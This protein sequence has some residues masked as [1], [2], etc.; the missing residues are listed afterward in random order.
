MKPLSINIIEN[1]INQW[2]NGVNLLSYNRIFNF[3]IGH[4]GVGK[5]YYFK[6]LCVR[7]FLKTGEQFVW[8]R[9]YKSEMSATKESWFDD[10]QEEFKDHTYKYN[11]RFIFIDGKKAG[12]FITLSISSTFKSKPFPLVKSI[13]FDEFLIDKSTFRY[14][15]EEVNIF[16]DLFETI[17]RKRDDVNAYFIGNAISFV[18][19]YF[20][21][22]DIKQTGKEIYLTDSICVQHYKNQYFINLKKKTRFGKL[23]KGTEYESYAIENNYIQD[24]KV[25]IEKKSSQAF[26]RCCFFYKDKYLGIW[27]DMQK[28][29]IYVDNTYEPQSSRVFTVLAE[30]H[31]PNMLM[32]KNIKS[33]FGVEIKYAF[34]E[35][36]MRFNTQTT[37]QLF[38][39]VINYL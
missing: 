24:K 2:Y 4:R 18:N 28:G 12:F 13:V 16:Q 38:Y 29:R 5:S 37:K 35:G 32:I 31:R 23:I 34:A 7:K 15:R 21:Y 1:D 14:L 10:I 30:D 39:E 9:R 36:I 11:G 8:V 27:K 19:P 20:I 25:F 33:T 3:I 26:F 17:A 6:R 22:Y